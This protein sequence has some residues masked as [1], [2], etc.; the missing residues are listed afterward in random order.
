MRIVFYLL[1]HFLFLN[2]ALAETTEN[3]IVRNQLR[4]N[5]EAA[6]AAAAEK[7]VAEPETSLTPKSK[8]VSASS[9]GPASSS[10]N[11]N[12]VCSQELSIFAMRPSAK[13]PPLQT[14]EMQLDNRFAEAVKE[15]IPQC[16]KVAANQLGMTLPTHVSLEQ[17]GAYNVRKINTPSG[18][19]DVWSRHS[20]GMAM[21]IS[22]I[23]LHN[24]YSSQ[25]ID[26]T[27]KTHNQ[28]FY[29]SF[30]SCWDNS[31]KNFMGKECTCS[32]GHAHTHDPSNHLHNDHMHI[33]LTCPSQSGVAGC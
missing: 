2:A 14:C 30:R 15:Y 8:P 27:D 32:I 5:Q 24:G 11:E 19:G 6:E 21:D 1:S 9:R 3:P 29:N 18:K 16:A 13:A 20:L 33:S 31:M 17:M 7:P 26:L 4:A 12:K 22:A 10:V 28:N 23:T 25:K